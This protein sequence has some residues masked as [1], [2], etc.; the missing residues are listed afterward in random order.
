MK[1]WLTSHKPLWFQNWNKKGLWTSSKS[2]F[3]LNDMIITFT[4]C[5]CLLLFPSI[6]AISY[7]CEGSWF[8]TELCIQGGLAFNF[9]NYVSGV[10]HLVKLKVLAPM[11]I[12]QCH[13]GI[14]IPTEKI[15]LVISVGKLLF[16]EVT[17]LLLD[18]PQEMLLQRLPVW[19]I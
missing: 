2:F 7:L 1:N 3:N 14:L 5:L 6:Y 16:P 12:I 9:P 10:K 15:Y 4:L 18:C 13:C 11:Q 17:E 19:R 8:Y